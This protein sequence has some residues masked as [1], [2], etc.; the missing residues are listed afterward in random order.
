MLGWLG[1]IMGQ[2]NRGWLCIHGFHF[3]TNTVFCWCYQTIFHIILKP[4]CEG[5]LFFL[6]QHIFKIGNIKRL[7]QQQYNL[8][9]TFW[10]LRL[11]RLTTWCCTIRRH[12][13][14]Q[15]KILDPIWQ[16]GEITEMQVWLQKWES[17]FRITY[18]NPA[19]WS[20]K[21]KFKRSTKINLSFLLKMI[22]FLE[23][24]SE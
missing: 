9:T 18:I 15:T 1:R 13:D 8:R 6:V 3:L 20:F 4:S 21:T 7:S 2:L 19:W 23:V 16:I 14:F 12:I 22:H 5:H 11:L 17:C 10:T 24:M